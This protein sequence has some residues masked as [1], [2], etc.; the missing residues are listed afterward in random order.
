[1]QE[2]VLL[3]RDEN[4]LGKIHH[5]L[6]LK[7]NQ[8]TVSVRDI[9]TERVFHEVEKYNQKSIDY[10]HGLVVPR[11]MEKLLNNKPERKKVDA[12]KQLTIALEAFEG[13]GFFIL[14]NNRQLESLDDQVTV[15]ADSSISFV[16][17]TPLVGG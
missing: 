16:K 8:A 14:V 13:N 6:Q 11:K 4:E 12:E 2:N 3:V 15:A 1:M 7:F 9:I 10:Q 5:T 17:L